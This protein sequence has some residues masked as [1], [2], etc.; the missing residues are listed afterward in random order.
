MAALAIQGVCKHCGCTDATACPDGCFWID[1]EHTVCSSK[2]CLDAYFAGH[3]RVFDRL[4]ES[5]RRG[6]AI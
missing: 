2:P 6:W 3:R 5:L 1:E 4:L